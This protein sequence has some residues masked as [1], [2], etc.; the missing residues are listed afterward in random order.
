MALFSALGV[1]YAGNLGF[2]VHLLAFLL[3]NVFVLICKRLCSC[4]FSCLVSEADSYKATCS[5][6]INL[7]PRIQRNFTPGKSFRRW[8]GRCLGKCEAVL[9][10]RTLQSSPFLKLIWHTICV[11]NI[12]MY[13]VLHFDKLL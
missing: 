13:T 8:I 5:E 10:C 2:H 1:S 11:R 12:L 4:D 7:T 6:E 3:P 9:M